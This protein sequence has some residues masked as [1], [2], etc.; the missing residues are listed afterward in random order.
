MPDLYFIREQR[1]LAEITCR[2]VEAEQC[3]IWT[4]LSTEQWEAA[5]KESSYIDTI[6]GLA[7]DLWEDFGGYFEHRAY[8]VL[9]VAPLIASGFAPVHQRYRWYPPFGSL[10]YESED[11]ARRFLHELFELGPKGSPL[12]DFRGEFGFNMPALGERERGRFV[13]FDPP[14]QEAALLFISFPS[15][16]DQRYER[17]PYLHAT[18]GPPFGSIREEWRELGFR[19]WETA[20]DL[21][22]AVTTKATKK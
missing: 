3:K 20:H 18:T 5:E 11:F 1:E 21:Q 15:E 22:H 8:S 16:Y 7:L 13:Y 10:L 4:D 9:D 17:I 14:D 2:L 19:A 12:V 6:G